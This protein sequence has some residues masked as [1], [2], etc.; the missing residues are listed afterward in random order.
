MSTLS[1]RLTESWYFDDRRVKNSVLN[2]VSRTLSYSPGIWRIMKSSW[3][4]LETKIEIN[5]IREMT[6]WNWNIVNI[7]AGRYASLLSYPSFGVSRNTLPSSWRWKAAG[8]GGGASCDIQCKVA[9]DING[10]EACLSLLNH[11]LSWLDISQLHLPKWHRSYAFHF[12]FPFYNFI[13]FTLFGSFL[14]LKVP[15]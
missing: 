15:S 2:T 13:N 1:W 3:S 6:N 9:K 14:H 7:G 4:G 5:R 8:G 10:R 12:Q 11:W